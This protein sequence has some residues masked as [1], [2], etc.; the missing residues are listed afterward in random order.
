MNRHLP[1]KAYEQP[2]LYSPGDQC[3]KKSDP[4]SEVIPRTDF[5]IANQC[6]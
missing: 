1:W 4:T 6:I 5:S 3:I 2:S